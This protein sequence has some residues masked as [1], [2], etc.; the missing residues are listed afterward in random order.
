MA[1]KTYKPVTPSLRT[2]VTVSRKGLWKGAPL[3]MLTRK[4]SE[5]AGRT[6]VI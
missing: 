5:K 1:L 6:L 3:K 2:L 4:K